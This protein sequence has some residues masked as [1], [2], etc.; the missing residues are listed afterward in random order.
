M[1]EHRPGRRAC[2]VGQAGWAKDQ[3]QKAVTW[4]K[5]D[6]GGRRDEAPDATQGPDS[7]GL[8]GLAHTLQPGHCPACVGAAVGGWPRGQGMQGG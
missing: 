6:E 1:G 8:G 5:R 3:R 7:S 2:R 4:A